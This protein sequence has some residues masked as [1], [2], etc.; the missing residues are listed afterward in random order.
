MAKVN[1]SPKLTKRNWE[2]AL[3][4]AYETRKIKKDKRKRMKNNMDPS[5]DYR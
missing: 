3:I 5:A 2:M 4:D 1:E